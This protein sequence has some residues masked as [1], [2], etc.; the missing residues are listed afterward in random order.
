MPREQ[1]AFK[2]LNLL[3]TKT[4]TFLNPCTKKY[5]NKSN[6]LLFNCSLGQTIKGNRNEK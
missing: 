2:N 6:R 4:F 3:V 1:K 5:T